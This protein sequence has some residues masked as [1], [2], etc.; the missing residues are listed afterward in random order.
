MNYSELSKPE[1]A[2]LLEK[3]MK[4][5][6]RFQGLKLSLD[7][8]RGKPCTEQLDMVSDIFDVLNSKSDFKLANGI[9][10]R[11]YG[12]VDGIPELKQL[13][14]K[15]FNVMPSE[16]AVSDGSSLA[17]MYGIV[18]HGKQFG[19]AGNVPWNKLPKVKFI[20]LTPGYDRHFGICETF[21]IEMISV[22]MTSDGINMDMIEALVANDSSIK[23]IWCVP[24]Y[25]NPT[26][27][28]YSDEVVDR[29]ANMKTA[30]SD[31]RI[32]W[33][34]A[35]FAH[36]LFKDE[37]LKDIMQAIKKA[38]NP[39][40]VFMFAS[41]SKITLA[42]AGVS[43]IISSENNIKEYK[44]RITFQTIGP[45]KVSQLMHFR[46]IKDIDNLKKIMEKHAEI[47]R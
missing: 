7:M 30:A 15:I 17:L 38:G 45:N 26:G 13:F 27:L 14:G 24:K 46:Y 8:S 42:G 19:F 36:T 16:V 22:P 20:C 41:T 29:L 35:Y 32:M 31:F 37:P 43:A 9:D 28:T 3:E 12:C 40:R 18:Q 33:D 2:E 4:Q 10:S 34:D 21:G 44:N 23:G 11:N 6:K 47:L 39:D 25:S 1:A 5:Y